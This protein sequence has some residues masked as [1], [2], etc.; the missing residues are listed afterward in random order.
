MKLARRKFLHFA[1]G[2][3]AL[4]AV[5]RAAKAQTYSTR[6]LT[7]IVLLAGLALLPSSIVAQ[8]GTLKQQLVGAWTLVSCPTAGNG[9]TQCVDPNGILILDA[10]GRYALVNAARGRPK[11]DS[12]V[13]PS[14]EQY[15]AAG[16]GLTAQFGTWSVNEADKTIT[17]HVEG[18]YFP[19]LEGTDLKSFFSLAGDELKIVG[20]SPGGQ[21]GESVYRRAK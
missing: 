21:T 1:A 19:I 4:P 3:V 7:M 8:Q 6:P 15:K 5:S 17:R 20:R 9:A 10:G 16:Q 18:A 11:F 2:A 12:G 14:A 13:V